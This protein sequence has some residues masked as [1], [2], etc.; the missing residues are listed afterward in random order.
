MGVAKQLLKRVGGGTGVHMLDF[1]V[2][3]I[4]EHLKMSR[5]R[6]I[7]IATKHTC[8]TEDSVDL[9]GRIIYGPH[10]GVGDIAGV[11]PGLHRV[12]LD[13]TLDAF[14]EE[15]RLVM[16]DCVEKVL[17]NSGVGPRE[18]DF[19]ITT[20]TTLN[21]VPSLAAM[22]ANRFSM[23][24]DVQTYSMTSQ[25]CASGL[26]CLELAKDFCKANPGTLALVVACECTSQGYY[27]G[28][29]RPFLAA[30]TL[31]R[32][33]GAA[34]L[35]TSRKKDWPYSKYEL[36]HAVQTLNTED[37]S[38]TCIQMGSDPKNM[39]KRGIALNPP[40][41]QKVAAECMKQNLMRLAVLALPI[42]ELVK[43]ARNPKTQ[44][45]FS[46]G[47]QHV[48]IHPGSTAVIRG[49]R[50]AL[51][52]GDKAA[53]PSLQ[54]LER[55]GNTSSSSTLY[56]LA[57][58]ESRQGV[59][60]GDRIL[61]LAMGSGFK[62]VSLVWEARRNIRHVP[63]RMAGRPPALSSGGPQPRQIPAPACS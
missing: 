19:I 33:G 50:K 48:L 22:I 54:T 55:F 10:V 28:N 40:A 9:M 45:N 14:L 46:T 57:N 13:Q 37:E 3:E 42:S 61:Q 6:Q 60:K 59:K 23:R 16:F 12:P 25:A 49:V 35:M 17:R 38:I 31:F 27:E 62:C 21:P 15:A 18:V 34:V 30:N 47:F 29:H 44:P 11:G 26:A 56:I 32:M 53:T 58:I 39:H 52:F 41:I 5:H 51:G 7:E 36:M 1:H 63:R 43:V 20:N 4:P 8:F 2:F 24:D